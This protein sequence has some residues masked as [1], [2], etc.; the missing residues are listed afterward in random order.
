M[1]VNLQQLPP[2]SLK[3]ASS[4][5]ATRITSGDLESATKSSQ[6]E[7]WSP[8]LSSHQRR[9]GSCANCTVKLNDARD[10]LGWQGKPLQVVLD[11]HPDV[12]GVCHLVHHHFGEAIPYTS[13]QVRF[14]ILNYYPKSATIFPVK[15][16]T[17][18]Q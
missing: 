1:R 8:T 13:R 4:N 14:L 17:H 11:Q 10:L 12:L 16:C 9:G 5:T 15:T 2:E 7:C 3:E 6:R 18:I